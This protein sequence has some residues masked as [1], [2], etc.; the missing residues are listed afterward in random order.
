M[1]DNWGPHF[2]V[3]SETLRTFSGRVLLREE[4]DESL[5]RKD[6]DSLGLTGPVVKIT[7]PWYMRKVDQLTW[8]KL[9]ESDDQVANF[10][11][12]WDTSTVENGEYEVLGLMHVFVREGNAQHVVARQNIVRVVVANRR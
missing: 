12:S 6:L 2:I 3:P 9:G 8:V 5:L 7:N 1:P 11:V 4:L 10:P